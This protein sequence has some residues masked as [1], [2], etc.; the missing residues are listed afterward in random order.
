MA[1]VAYLDTWTLREIVSKKPDNRRRSAR[2]FARLESGVYIVKVPQV[3]VGEAVTT[4]MRDFDPS[5][6]RDKVGL[7]METLARVADPATCFPPPDPAAG[8]RAERLMA[9]DSRLTKTDALLAAQALMDRESRKV[10]TANGILR[11]SE[12]I[13]EED[14]SM[15]DDGERSWHLEFGD[16]V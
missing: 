3:V 7:I 13:F 11:S 10:V 8:R 4:V 2:R 6:W 14:Q 1:V 5:E 9:R 16:R 12:L 15:I